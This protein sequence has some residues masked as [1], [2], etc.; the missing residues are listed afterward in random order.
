MV[1]LLIT[2]GAGF[3][4][5]NLVRLLAP[6]MATVAADWDTPLPAELGVPSVDMDVRDLDRVRTVLDRFRPGA[7]VHA[8]GNKNVRDCE[9]R[10][11]E[12]FRTNAGGTRNVARACCEIGAHL[13]YLS[14]DLVFDCERGGYTE[15]DVPRPALVY[16][17][18]K[19]QGEVFAREECPGAA[20]CRSGGIYG[21]R[22][23][24]LAW[25]RGELVAQRTVEAFTDV[26]NT[27]TYVGSLADMLEA[28][29]RRR[30]GGVFH[31]VGAERTSRYDFFRA[32]AET[33]ALDASLVAAV[34]AGGK[35]REMLLQPD[36]SLRSE[37]TAATLGIA[38][39]S[40]REGLRRMREQGGV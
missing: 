36:A 5:Q 26:C 35:R 27:P 40:V 16:G 22:S 20:V 13:L 1:E 38:A 30:L 32:F 6:R 21:R 3:V 34:A 19:R 12:A 7:V 15:E 4:G 2:G 23:P 37:R 14:T 10:P 17:E 39:L 18:T 33:F 11:E 31:T 24:L 29:A 28:V 9:E 8:A 25:L